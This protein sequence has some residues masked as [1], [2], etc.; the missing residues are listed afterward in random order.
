MVA[1]IGS[2]AF[3]LL[4]DRRAQVRAATEEVARAAALR[5]MLRD[6]ITTGEVLPQAGGPPGRGGTTG[7]GTATTSGASDALVLVTPALT[8]ARSPMT[9][10]RLFIDDDP[11]TPERGLTMQYLTSLNDT[12]TTRELEPQVAGLRVEYLDQRTNRWYPGS[13]AATIQPIA[14]RLTL[15]GTA[16]APL[17]AL[18]ELPLVAAVG[19]DPVGRRQ[20]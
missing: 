4:I 9:L 7:A 6:W 13:E 19:G 5:A 11:T 1:G 3:E 2:A 14:V 15:Q 8:P 17:P 16:D 12:L 10:M 20:P 18:L